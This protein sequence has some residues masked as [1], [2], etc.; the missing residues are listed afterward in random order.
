M[1]GYRTQSDVYL[2]EVAVFYMKKIQH[3]VKTGK[4]HERKT[5]GM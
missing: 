5:Y 4:D 2:P 3:N 1:W